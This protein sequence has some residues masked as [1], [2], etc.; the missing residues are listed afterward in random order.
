M[1]SK[2]DRGGVGVRTDSERVGRA[3]ISTESEDTVAWKM[4]KKSEDDA[5]D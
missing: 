2:K 1:K 3:E 4:G 5:D